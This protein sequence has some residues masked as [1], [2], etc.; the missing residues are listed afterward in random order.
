[1][2]Q[3]LHIPNG[4]DVRKPRMK[5]AVHTVFS[6]NHIED[7]GAF[8]RKAGI[9]RYDSRR[10]YTTRNSFAPRQYSTEAN[11]NNLNLFRCAC[12]GHEDVESTILVIKN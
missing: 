4:F 8:A 12:L 1:M 6:L 11:G 2:H 9:S 7:Q 5:G 3:S 10:K